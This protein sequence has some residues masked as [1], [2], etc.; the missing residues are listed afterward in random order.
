MITWL[1]DNSGF[2]MAILTLLYVF[3]T[4][5]ILCANN[6]TAKIAQKQLA[7]MKTQ[8]FELNRGFLIASFN[9]VNNC[10]VLTIKNI[11]KSLVEK[12]K[13]TIS[14]SWLEIFSDK[15]KELL[16]NLTQQEIY[17][18][19]NQELNYFIDMIPIKNYE[20]HKNS[21]V[22][23][24]FEYNTLAKNIKDEIAINLNPILASYYGWNFEELMTK[25]L[26]TSIDGIAKNVSTQND[27][28]A[29]QNNL[30]QTFNKSIETSSKVEPQKRTKTTKR[31]TK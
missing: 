13:I 1:N 3:A 21:T 27:I 28:L 18:A 6:K 4:V 10:F 23:F 24:C 11:G 14:S 19:P 2:I 8:T 9:V 29:R 25:N 31:T 7:E 20:K 17:L 22:I 5:F 12:A 15:E 16:I 26:T 30:L